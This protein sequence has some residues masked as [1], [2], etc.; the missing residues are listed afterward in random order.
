MGTVVFVREQP[1]ARSLASCGAQMGGW[2]EAWT[3]G[4]VDRKI[5]E[6]HNKWWMDK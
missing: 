3:V 5:K 6:I 2:M 4:S 1:L